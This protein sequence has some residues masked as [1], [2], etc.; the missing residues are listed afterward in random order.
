MK[1]ITGYRCEKCGRE[2]YPKHVRCPTCKSINFEEFE[3]GDEGKLITYTKLYSIPVGIMQA[4]PLV[5]GVVE[6]KNKTK[7]LG[8]LT[9]DNPEVGMRMCPVWGKLRKVIGEDVYGFKFE[10]RE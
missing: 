8:Q 2:M 6:F 9:I 10:P 1:G 7:V 3:L 4:P 5:I